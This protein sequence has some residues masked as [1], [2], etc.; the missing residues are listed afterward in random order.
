MLYQIPPCIASL[1]TVTILLKTK[2]NENFMEIKLDLNKHCIQT[3][4][5]STYN[6]LI[7]KYFKLNPSE[8]TAIIESEISLLKEALE[9]LDFAWLRATYP[10]LQGSGADEILIA[11]DADNKIT[12]SINGRVI[13]ATYQN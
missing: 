8:N 6:Q 11:T 12:I 10:E 4:I 9:N 5:K 3:A 13:H 2:D 7:S 1:K